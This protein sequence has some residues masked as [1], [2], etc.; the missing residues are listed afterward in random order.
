MKKRPKK[1]ESQELSSDP[2]KSSQDK[3]EPTNKVG[4]PR[5]DTPEVLAIIYA[6]LTQ[7]PIDEIACQAAGIS[8]R[9]YDR[10]RAE[11]EEF[12]LKTDRLTSDHLKE[13]Y[14]DVRNK[15]PWK[16][17]KNVGKKWFKEHVE[18]VLDEERHSVKLPDGREENI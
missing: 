3:N 15:D 10:W 18:I 2:M 1:K 14:G 4:R 9:T 7:C 11:N 8:M 6:S 12:R 16:L 17:L 13:L 5:T